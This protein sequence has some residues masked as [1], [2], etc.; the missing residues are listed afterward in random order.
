MKYFNIIF[1]P[2]ESYV[3]PIFMPYLE[4]LII[5]VAIAGILRIIFGVII[6]AFSK[7]AEKSENKFDD[8]LVVI[9]KTIKPPFYLVIAALLA[10]QTFSL[11]ET[12]STILEYA[13]IITLIVQVILAATAL[14]AFTAQTII[15]QDQEKDS[16]TAVLFGATLLKIIVWVVGLLFLLSN[17]GVNVTSLAASLGIGGI[18]IALALQNILSDLFSSFTIYFDKPF[19][20]GDFIVVGDK[21][22]TVEHIGIKTTR[23]RA[24]QGEQ[25]VISN[26][27]LT[28]SQIQN[29]KRLSERRSVMSIGVTYDTPQEKMKR[30]PDLI[31]ESVMGVKQVRFDRAHFHEFGDSA[32]IFEVVFFVDSP[33]YVEYMDARQTIALNIKEAFEREG[34]EMAFPTQTLYIKK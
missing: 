20:V 24:L 27:E 2:L 14:I 6:T 4:A 18:A 1:E 28:Q 12:L 25:I 15:D 31:K 30:I 8:A 26:Q 13:L 17:M 33:E 10:I 21:M 16:T 5:F 34:I 22:G 32:L 9:F 7:R 3:S 23:L 29:F 19:K 11:G